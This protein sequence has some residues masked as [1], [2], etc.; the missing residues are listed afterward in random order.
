MRRESHSSSAHLGGIIR[1]VRIAFV[2]LV[3]CA[4]LIVA[5]EMDM[6]SRHGVRVELSCEVGWAT[7]REKLHYGQVDAAHA[8][9]GMALALRLGLS[10]PRFRVVAPFV[11]NLNGNGITLS[12]DLWNRGARDANTL[13]KLVRSTRQ[14][15]LTF[16][17]VSR[18][19]SHFFL[20]RGWLASGG[21]HPENDV[22]LVV[23]PP[24]QMV[25]NLKAGLIDGFCVGEPWNAAAVTDG[26]GWVAATSE[27]L[28]PN[29]PEKALLVAE[30][31]TAS[32]REETSA[33]ISALSEACRYCDAAENRAA[34][35]SMLAATG[36]FER[37]AAVLA[38]SLV[39]P[40]DLGTGESRPARDFHIF[41]RRD[42]NTPTAERG[43]WL[44]REFAAHGLLAGTDH[45]GGAHALAD[46]WG[47]RALIAPPISSET[48]SK[49]RPNPKA[50]LVA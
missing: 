7:V 8:P 30:E 31:F 49:L 14:R 42:A 35:V 15:C 47:D 48:K 9:A 33:I 32:H 10:A 24:T 6:F 12:R 27:D 38:P 29:H 50:I 13:G 26:C 41:H 17:V 28:A 4:P 5:R 39:G 11:F 18:H 45:A 36:L 21:I 3:D 2:P 46:C 20:L 40:F 23:L 22:R 25:A 19:S 37:G 34:L 43:A 44:L 16:G 1:P